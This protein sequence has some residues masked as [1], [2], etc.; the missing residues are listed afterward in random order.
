MKR[1]FIL[2][3]LAI[4]LGLYMEAET[5]FVSVLEKTPDA[6]LYNFESSS[7][8]ESGVLD[9][10]FDMG[11]IVSNTPIQNAS[12]FEL[13]KTLQ[14]AQE[15]GASSILVVELVYFALP[16]TQKKERAAPAAAKF[17]RYSVVSGKLLKQIEYN[18]PSLSK[19]LEEDMQQAKEQT[20]RLFAKQ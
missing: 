12:S 16:N 17:Y 20:R 8:W 9:A 1:A 14:K 13:Q 6:A 18:L 11:A 2:F 19:N 10:L 5:I 4:G 15:G 3:L 7:A